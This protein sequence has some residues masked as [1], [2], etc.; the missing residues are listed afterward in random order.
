VKAAILSLLAASAFGAD[1]AI[2]FSFFRNNGEDGLYLATSDDGLTWR[3]LHGDRPLV[4]PEVG[5]QKLMRDPSIL[6]G[7]DG[8]FH[9]V[10]TTSWQGRTIG[11]AQSKGLLQWSPQRAIEILPEEPGLQNCWAPELFY[12]ASSRGY[13]VVW[14]STIRGRFPETLGAGSG[15]NN[16]RLYCFR[17]RDFRAFCRPA[18]FY[19]PR[20]CR[21]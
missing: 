13:L 15:D 3:P 4:R 17:T 7:P 14:A 2:L 1:D 12:D 20:I 18:L 19:D 11:Y 10:W 16:H 21:I 8:M 5:E 6:R 9:M